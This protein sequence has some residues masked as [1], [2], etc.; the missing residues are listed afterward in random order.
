MKAALALLLPLLL[1]GCDQNMVQQPRYDS[2]EEAPLFGS[3]QAMQHPPDGVVARDADRGDARPPIT[4]ALLARGADRFG[5]YCAPCHGADGSGDGV[6]PA[7]G[8]PQPP[9][10]LA[11]RLIAAPDS[12]IYRVITDGYGVMYSYADRVPPADRWAIAAHIRLLQR[13]EETR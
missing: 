1:A 8:F 3:G 7:R 5:I 13:A 6:I 10:L 12:H 4:A 11:A 9:N 2:Y